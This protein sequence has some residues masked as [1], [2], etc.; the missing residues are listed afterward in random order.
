MLLEKLKLVNFRQ[1]YNE[2]EIEF[3]TDPQKNITLI[4]GENGV[5]KT[6]ILNSILWCLYE[7]L[8]HDFEQQKELIC[9]QAIKDGVKSCRVELSFQYEEKHYLAQR[10]LHNSNQSLL[11]LFEINNSNYKDVP[12]PTAFVN[13]ILPSDMAEYFFFHGEG[14]SN[15]NATKSGEK[16]RRAIRDIL[17]FRLAETAIKDLKE[18]NAVWTKALNELTNLNYEQNEL[19]KKKSIY[20]GKKIGLLEKLRTFKEEKEEGAFWKANIA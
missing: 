7:K 1:F 3:S 12:N 15:I 20:E 16:F 5:G 4:H 19:V 2:T 13:N 8:T 17:G 10:S 6:T 11:K 18:I 9:I 14:V